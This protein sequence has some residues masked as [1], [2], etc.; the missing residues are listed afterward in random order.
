MKTLLARGRRL[1]AW[2]DA[3]A[4]YAVLWMC[5]LEAVLQAWLRI[6][7]D[8]AW[9]RAPGGLLFTLWLIRWARRTH[10]AI[11]A[12]QRSHEAAA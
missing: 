6:A 11:G 1:S 4:D 5:L 9:W 10:R 3:R 8:G 2:L 7:T 12:A